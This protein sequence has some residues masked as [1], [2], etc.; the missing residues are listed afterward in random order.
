[1]A[2]AYCHVVSCYIQSVWAAAYCHVVSCTYS[3]CGC[4]ILSCS[5]LHCTVCVAAAYCHVVSI[6]SYKVTAITGD[7]ADGVRIEQGWGVGGGGNGGPWERKGVAVWAVEPNV[8]FSQCLRLERRVASVGII[9][10]QGTW[11]ATRG[12]VSARKQFQFVGHRL[13]IRTS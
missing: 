4:C 6:L 1:M 12:T 9:W 5:E 11:L 13:F 2:A 8:C 10:I 7:R 3:L